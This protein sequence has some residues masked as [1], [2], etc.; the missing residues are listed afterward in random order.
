MILQKT[1][2]GEGQATA[3]T[4]RRSPEI[5]IPLAA[6]DAYPDFWR[7]PGR[8]S[9]DANHPG[10]FDRRNVPMFLGGR[11]ILVN[12]MTW[13]DRHD[14]RLRNASLR[15]AGSISDILCMERVSTPGSS[16]EYLVEVVPKESRRYSPLLARCTRLVRNSRRRF[17][18]Y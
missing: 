9:E 15:D 7:W 2:V 10:K 12:M 11:R 8:F 3:G 1:D 13:P 16:L 14:F 17:G 4:A 5:F 18:Y 6:R